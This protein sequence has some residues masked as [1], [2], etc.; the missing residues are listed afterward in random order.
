MDAETI[1]RLVKAVFYR[2]PVAVVFERRI[3]IGDHAHL[4]AW[5]V[6]GRITFP[7]RPDLRWRHGLITGAERTARGGD[8]RSIPIT[9][10][11]SWALG[12]FRSDDDPAVSHRIFSKLRHCG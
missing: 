3:F 10:V 8:L 4:P 9:P 1:R 5:R 7:L 6:G 11:V 12:A 2:H